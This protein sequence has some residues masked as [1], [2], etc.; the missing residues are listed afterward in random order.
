MSAKRQ[1]TKCCYQ[2]SRVAVVESIFK[3]HETLP[4]GEVSGYVNCRS[5]K[6]SIKLLDKGKN[7]KHRFKVLSTVEL[8][9]FTGDIVKEK[10]NVRNIIFES[11]VTV[12]IEYLLESSTTKEKI[13][14]DMENLKNS[15]NL[16]F[17]TTL[18]NLLSQT[19]FS[20]LPISTSFF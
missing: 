16:V 12:E 13:E 2:P 1:S 8:K 15:L 14:G 18:R 5:L 17:V 3:K 4:T 11:K 7:G 10:D 20:S 19:D 6:P 9:A